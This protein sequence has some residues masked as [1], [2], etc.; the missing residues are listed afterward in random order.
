MAVCAETICEGFDH[1]E[2]PETDTREAANQLRAA[3]VHL[4]KLRIAQGKYDTSDQFLEDTLPQLPGIEGG[5][6]AGGA[7]S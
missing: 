1:A 7:A 5:G 6:G 4:M 2:A 3:S